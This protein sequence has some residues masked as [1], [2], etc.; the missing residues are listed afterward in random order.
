MMALLSWDRLLGAIIGGILAWCILAALN[1]AI[2]LPQAREDERNKVAAEALVKTIET[3]KS[4]EKTDVEISVGDADAL[5]EHF[6]LQDN[7]RAECL[8]RLAKA[9]AEP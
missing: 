5:C 7:D 9:S 1:Q 6:G 2:W 4:R 3:L 8:R